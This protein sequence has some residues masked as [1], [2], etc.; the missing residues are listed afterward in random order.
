M[1]LGINLLMKL[2]KEAT[3]VQI[4]G[5]QTY[6]RDLNDDIYKITNISTFFI[7]QDGKIRIVFAYGNNNFTSEM[8]IIEI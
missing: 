4:S 2:L 7:G 5:Y 8:D 3:K 6:T 1:S